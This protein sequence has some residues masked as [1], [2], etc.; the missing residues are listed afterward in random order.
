MAHPFCNQDIQDAG[1]TTRS[2]LEA[3]PASASRHG[4]DSDRDG[5][6]ADGHQT[7]PHALSRL[8][9]QQQPDRQR[10]FQGRITGTSLIN[11]DPTLRPEHSFSKDLNHSI[12]NESATH[13][14]QGF[15]IKPSQ[16]HT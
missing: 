9:Y 16:L 8:R 1:T 10:L 12:N 4:F 3:Q 6:L 11:N 13:E 5:D 15:H 2:T 14:T 7:G